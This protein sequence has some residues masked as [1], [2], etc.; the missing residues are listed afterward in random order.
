LIANIAND[1]AILGVA[2]LLHH[3]KGKF[4]KTVAWGLL[5]AQ[6][7]VN[8]KAA[9]HNKYVTLDERLYVSPGATNIQWYN[10]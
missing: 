5:A 7:A 1:A 4:G 2:E 8:F 3:S 9:W 6:T 10:P